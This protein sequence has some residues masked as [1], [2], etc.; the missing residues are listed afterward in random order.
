MKSLDE[1][2]Y[3]AAIVIFHIK[4]IVF[5]AQASRTNA[6]GTC[7]AIRTCGDGLTKVKI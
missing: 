4:V 5:L 1:S 2:A 7:A 6:F 3:A